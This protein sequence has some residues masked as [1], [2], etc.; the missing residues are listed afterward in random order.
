MI[1]LAGGDT[2]ARHA[3]REVARVTWEDVHAAEPGRHRRR[4]LRLR[5]RGQPGPRRRAAGERR[6]PAGV[7]VHAVDAN[8]SWA[9]PGTRLVDGVEELARILHR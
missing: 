2:P 3:R 8:A 7:P 6:A 5:P 1:E 4:A 9:R